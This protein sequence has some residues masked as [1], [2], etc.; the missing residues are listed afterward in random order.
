MDEALRTRVAT[1]MDD[2]PDPGAVA[3]LAALLDTGEEAALR[4]RFRTGLAFGTAGLRGELRAGP[5]GMNLA[6][7]ER[8]AAGL[9]AWLG[10]GRTVAVGYDARHRSAEFA[11]AC[12]AV[13]GG[14][15]LEVRLLPRAL[16]TPVLA[17]AVRHLGA[18]AGIMVT[19]SH[20]P[21]RDNGMKVY[22]GDGAQLVPPADAEIEAAIAAVGP[23][24]ALPRAAVPV[25]V[26][27]EPVEAYV[28][29]TAALSLVPDRGVRVAATAMHGVGRATLDAVLARAGFALPAWEPDQAEPDPD[30]PTVAFPNP[31]EPGALDRVLA[32][33]AR[34]AADLV[35]AVD[36]DADR[37]A[38]AVG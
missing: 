5:N 16:P 36:P 25:P 1:W 10:A 2:D 20:N 27:E 32:L 18:D 30:F 24:R 13:L 31:E 11:R 3:E 12:A 7:V 23:L 34:E 28:A 8:A 22:L 4:E 15:G 33:A 29:A 17:F 9:A 19:A 38:V 35:V 26:G 14:A 37:C 21:P 6:V